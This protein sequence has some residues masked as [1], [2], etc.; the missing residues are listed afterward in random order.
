MKFYNHWLTDVFEPPGK[1]E[2]RS[3]EHL[4][5]FQPDVKTGFTNRKDLLFSISYRVSETGFVRVTDQLLFSVLDISSWLIIQKYFDQ[6]FHTP[7]LLFTIVLRFYFLKLL[8]SEI[9]PRPRVPT[10]N[11]PCKILSLTKSLLQVT[12]TKDTMNIRHL[13]SVPSNFTSM[14]D[15][16]RIHGSAGLNFFVPYVD[17]ISRKD[18]FL[19]DGWPVPC[20]ESLHNTYVLGVG[21]RSRQTC[22]WPTHRE[23]SPSERRKEEVVLPR[24]KVPNGCSHHENTTSIRHRRSEEKGR[25]HLFTKDERIRT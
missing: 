22:T 13:S 10:L 11:S 21:P 20:L 18:L 2:L 6:R 12:G 9:V 16:S 3:L 7:S 5:L 4:N 17:L 8:V 24:T 23:T 14:W 1:E 15:D 19:Y 25:R